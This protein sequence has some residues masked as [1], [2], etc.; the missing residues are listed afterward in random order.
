MYQILPYIEQ[1]AIYN[2]R[3]G[4]GGA[5][6][7]FQ[8]TRLDREARADVQLPVARHRFGCAAS[9]STSWATTRG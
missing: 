6:A 5:N 9:T 4:D 8:K 3:R 7:G 2:M 1:Q